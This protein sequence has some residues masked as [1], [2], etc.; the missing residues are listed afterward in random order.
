MQTDNINNIASNS[1]KTATHCFSCVFG[2]Q[3]KTFL[4]C[5]KYIGFASRIILA[6][7][8]FLAS[9]DKIIHPERFLEA[10]RAYEILPNFT[11]PFFSIAMPWIEFIVAL[12][13]LLGFWT[14][15]A[16]GVS[17][18]LFFVFMG[19][20][21]ITIWRGLDINCGCF[22]LLGQDHKVSWEVFFRDVLMAIPAVILLIKFVPFLSLDSLY[23]GKNKNA[24]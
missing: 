10:V 1:I 12:L 16:S 6:S 3:N 18:G 14:R 9:A 21:A 8:F 24:C 7:I 23:S 19:S 4:S 11:I 15:A 22:D 20:I 5:W 13:L 2:F 17:L